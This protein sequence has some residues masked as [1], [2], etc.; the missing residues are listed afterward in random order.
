MF[1]EGPSF[2]SRTR[3]ELKQLMDTPLF[4]ETKLRI[5]LPDGRILESRFSPRERMCHVREEVL[6]V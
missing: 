2:E 4:T 6:K 5:K 1:T 3:K